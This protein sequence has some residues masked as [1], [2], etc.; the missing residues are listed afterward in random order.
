MSGE[1]RLIVDYEGLVAM[2]WPYSK[3]HTWRL[4]EP[5]I[6]RSSGSRIKGTY[7]EWFVPNLRV[8]PRGRKMDD[9]CR[10]SPYVWRVSDILDYLKKHHII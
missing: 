10:N 2:G 3:A 6:R 5:E 9:E 7:K 8:F 4:M 1:Q